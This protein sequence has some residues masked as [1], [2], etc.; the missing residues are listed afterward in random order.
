MIF[1]F[2][3]IGIVPL[4]FNLYLVRLGYGP[5][6]IGILNGI[7]ALANALVAVPA[8]LLSERIGCRKVMAVGAVA[9]ILGTAAAPLA[10]I[11]HGT[12]ATALLS[13]SAFF[14]GVGMVMFLVA[15]TP[16]MVGLTDEG[17]RIFA[18][19]ARAVIDGIFALLGSLVGGI[20]PGLLAG[21]AGGTPYRGYQL[22]LI[23]A[24]VSI[25]GM[26]V[27]FS[28]LTEEPDLRP[29]S[30]EANPPSNP[31]TASSAYINM[32]VAARILFVTF[33][34]FIARS[35]FGVNKPFLNVYLDVE[36]RIPSAGIGVG[37]GISQIGATIG[38]F[39]IPHFSN[40][41]GLRRALVL[42]MIATAGGLV[43]VGVSSGWGVAFLGMFV[44]RTAFSMFFSSYLM[45]SQNVVPSRN[46]SRASGIL[47]LAAGVGMTGVSSVGGFIVASAGY[48]VV[49][50][51]GAALMVLSGII[52][53]LFRLDT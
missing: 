47:Y 8:G 51:L 28:R 49:F 20:L 18:F 6:A 32:G 42:Y 41:F 43:L 45:Y 50:I 9:M 4:L 3:F 26:L 40:R 39:L 12:V 53:F 31:S 35:G 22:G 2:A 30:A 33:V 19:S 21:G 34:W 48:S 46:R 25:A 1:N 37:I 44:G 16:Y 24:P 23:V 27:I 15:C 14:S 17:E 29:S 13:F 36:L 5:K 10:G 7:S 11:F 52:L 38:A